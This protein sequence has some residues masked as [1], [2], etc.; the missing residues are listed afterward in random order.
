MAGTVNALV[1]TDPRFEQRRTEAEN[2]YDG[3]QLVAAPLAN[4][5]AEPSQSSL[6][7]FFQLAGSL[8]LMN[9]FDAAHDSF[10]HVHSKDQTS[11]RR[12]ALLPTSQRARRPRGRAESANRRLPGRARRPHEREN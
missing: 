4:R 11:L 9:D 2:S 5:R 1:E 10:L 3:R 8:R 12:A 7:S 6:V